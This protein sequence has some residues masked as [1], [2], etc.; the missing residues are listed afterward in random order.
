VA[1]I[2]WKQFL[3]RPQNS[4]TVIEYYNSTGS[5]GGKNLAK[6]VPAGIIATG[7][8][9]DE[10]KHV[11]FKPDMHLVSTRS[12]S[13]LSHDYLALDLVKASISSKFRSIPPKVNDGSYTLIFDIHSID[14]KD[15]PLMTVEIRMA[16]E[17]L[18][19]AGV[20][21]ERQKSGIVE[22]LDKK[23]TALKGAYFDFKLSGVGVAKAA[24]PEDSFDDGI[25]PAKPATS[26][27]ARHVDTGKDEALEIE[28][29][30]VEQNKEFLE[31]IRATRLLRD[32][33]MQTNL[34]LEFQILKRWE[35]V[36]NMRRKQGFTSS[37]LKIMVKIIETFYDRDV[38][39]CEEECRSE[40]EEM[41]E[42]HEVNEDTRYQAYQ[43]ELLSRQFDEMET[44]E[45]VEVDE[46]EEVRKKSKGK[47]K[48]R[49]EEAEVNDTPV[50]DVKVF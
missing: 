10:V 16:K 9:E 48:E 27:Y 49:K 31:D 35:S 30:R 5:L 41:R 4:K 33:E 39:H 38:A 50:D 26:F 12:R 22:F 36:K 6:I 47:K 25:Y 32:T 11:G 42:L 15:H 44:A 18:D 23:L 34:I 20:L 24:E 43:V 40:L 19:M 45:V 28:T 14:I 7:N 13:T 2:P 46:E 8:M 37:D 1:P 29:R 21:K 3:S 17:C